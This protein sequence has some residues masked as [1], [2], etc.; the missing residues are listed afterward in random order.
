MV[1]LGNGFF[2][3][4]GLKVGVKIER[5]KKIGKIKN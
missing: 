3:T 5:L 1:D 2:L 4:F